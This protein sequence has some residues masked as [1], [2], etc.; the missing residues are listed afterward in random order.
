MRITGQVLVLDAADLA[1]ESAFWAVLLGGTVA[2]REDWHSVVVGGAV[3]MGVQLAP[4]HQAPSWPDGPAQQ[5]HLD[6]Y[7]EDITAAHDQVTAAGAR[8][9][10][11]VDDAAAD[12]GFRVYADPAGHPFCLCWGPPPM[13][14]MPAAPLCH[15]SS[16]DGQT[17]P[18]S[19]G[20]V[21]EVVDPTGDRTREVLRT[22]MDD[23]ASRHH[24]RPATG[25]E[26]DAALADDPAD[27]LVLPSGLLV[28]AT[29]ADG[30]T[31]ACA[32]LRL[33]PGGVGEVVK[34]F[35]APSGRARGLGRRLVEEVERLAAAHGRTRVRLEARAD[36]VE[37]R[38]LYARLGYAEV[39]PFNDGPYADHWLAKDIT[40]T[41]DPPASR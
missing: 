5:V 41:Q 18:A 30:I 6:L 2:A 38:R 1:T 39:A 11:T 22:S 28:V 12:N 24:R 14:E 32:G 31:L 37:A 26:V 21:L 34:V 27:D 13:G 10:R 4:G 25:A 33:L 20:V 16:T 3:A 29:D 9:L 7:V 19:D 23:V 36:L 35:V 17:P 8:L 15:R 40:S